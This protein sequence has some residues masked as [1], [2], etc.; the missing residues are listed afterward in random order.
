MPDD[1]TIR[2][3]NDK[4][5]QLLVRLRDGDQEA[6]AE[7]YPLFVGRLA[8]IGAAV[9][10]LSF[11]ESDELAHDTIVRVFEAIHTYRDRGYPVAWIGRIHHTTIANWFRVRGRQPPTV[12]INELKGF[13]PSETSLEREFVSGESRSGDRIDVERERTLRALDCVEATLPQEELDLLAGKVRGKPRNDRREKL[14][15]ALAHL[16]AAFRHCLESLEN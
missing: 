3:L 9:Y 6:M 7:F 8:R 14:E 13:D 10:G 12:S 11:S 5:H 1:E 2:A 4:A 16:E 15:Q